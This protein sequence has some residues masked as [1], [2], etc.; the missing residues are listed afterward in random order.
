MS[1]KG[2]ESSPHLALIA[3]LLCTY[4]LAAAE[5]L[6]AAATLS[7]HAGFSPDRLNAPTNLALTASFAPAEITPPPVRRFTLYA[8][9]GMTVDTRGAGTCAAA[10]LERLG[11]SGCPENSRAG[12]GGG[13]GVVQLPAE[14]I[15]ERYTLD[16]F[17]AAKTSGHLRLL[18]YA[19]ATLPIG[20]SLVLSARQIFAPAPYGLAFTVEVPPIATFPGAPDASIES[21]FVT[22]GSSNVAYYEQVGGKR[23]LVPLRGLVVPKHCPRGGFPTAGAVDFA[24]GSSLLV[25]ETI[26][27]PHH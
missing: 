2:R 13:V 27:C 14:T 7:V 8:P 26:P 11:P 17:F 22:V 18:V 3:L 16:F 25:K 19:N 4:L 24:D 15:H 5:P 9:A 12:F 10:T 6:A 23:K 21:A 1:R 20:V